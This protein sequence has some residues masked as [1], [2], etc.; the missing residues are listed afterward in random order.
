MNLRTQHVAAAMLVLV[1]APALAHTETTIAGGFASGFRHPLLGG[2]HLLAMVAVGIW[3]A[4]LGAPLLWLLPVTFPMLMVLG[5][6]AA[7][8][9]PSSTPAPGYASTA[10]GVVGMFAPPATART[11]FAMSAR[12]SSASSSFCVAEGMGTS[13]GTSHGRPRPP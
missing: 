4:V 11:P 3:G 7:L 12:A 5:A 6:L 8:A 9:G 2:D 10:S 13:T 1:A